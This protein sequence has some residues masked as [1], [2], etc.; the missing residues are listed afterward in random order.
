MVCVGLALCGE[1]PSRQR[2]RGEDAGV[3]AG[4][5]QVEKSFFGSF[6]SKKELLAFFH[7]AHAPQTFT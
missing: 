3:E 7:L 2:G 4:G 6:F 5:R 1:L